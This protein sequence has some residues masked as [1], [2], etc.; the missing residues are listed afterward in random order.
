MVSIVQLD[1]IS[2]HDSK[3]C[4]VTLVYCLHVCLSTFRAAAAERAEDKTGASDTQ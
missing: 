4:D 1:L 3:G 2:S